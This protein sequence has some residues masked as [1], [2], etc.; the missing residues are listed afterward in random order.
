MDRNL[1]EG[2]IVLEKLRAVKAAGWGELIIKIK[3]S[4]VIYCETRI[5]EQVE[6]RL[7]EK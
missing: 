4:H 5:G 2:R 3:G 7:D 1:E 6:M